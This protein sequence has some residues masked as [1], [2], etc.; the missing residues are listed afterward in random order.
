MATV[1]KVSKIVR[2]DL[3]SIVHFQVTL[4]AYLNK[5]ELTE[6][7]INGI[8]FLSIIGEKELVKFCE[9]AKK[10]KLFKTEQ[11]ARNSINKCVKDNLIIKRGEGRKTIKVNPELKIQTQG[12]ILCENKFIYLEDDTKKA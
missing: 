10:Q 6:G 12:S 11:S 9:L 1:N 4:Y 8:T 2:M 7:D 5:L 3:W